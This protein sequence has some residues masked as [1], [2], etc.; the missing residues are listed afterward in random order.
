M[1]PLARLGE[2]ERT[3]NRGFSR[4]LRT[5]RTG[6]DFPARIAAPLTYPLPIEIIMS[7]VE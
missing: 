7:F 3:V 5:L 4:T 1:A 6:V 2:A